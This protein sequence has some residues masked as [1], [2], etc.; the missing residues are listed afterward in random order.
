MNSGPWGYIIMFS[1]HVSIKEH[2]LTHVSVTLLPDVVDSN[3]GW[4][5]IARG[6]LL[7]LTNTTEPRPHTEFLGSL[8]TIPGHS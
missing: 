7:K 8:N 3:K 4:I 6:S 5:Q 1:L 2:S